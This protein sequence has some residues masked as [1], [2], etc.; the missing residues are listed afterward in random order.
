MMANNTRIKFTDAILSTITIKAQLENILFHESDIVLW[1]KL[2]ERVVFVG[3]NFGELSNGYEVPKKPAKGKRGRQRQ[4]KK[5]KRRQIQGNGKYMNSQ[6]TFIVRS[7]NIPDKIYKVKVFRTGTIQIPGALCNNLEDAKDA[8]EE[9]RKVLINA[10]GLSPDEAQL[11]KYDDGTDI[12]IVMKNSRWRINGDNWIMNLDLL[13]KDLSEIKSDLVDIPI[14]S[15]R[16]NPERYQG[17][18][19][20]VRI[21]KEAPYSTFKVFRSGKINLTISSNIEEIDTL[22]HWFEDYINENHTKFLYS[23]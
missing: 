18:L 12:K 1:A 17:F 14:N 23:V 20:K 10:L 2:N 9:I 11:A 21:N 5:K 4:E 19:F 6:A 7:T 3:G 22:K 13:H 16:Y 15:I 8:I